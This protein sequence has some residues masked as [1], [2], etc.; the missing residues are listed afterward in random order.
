MVGYHGL[1]RFIWL[2]FF[3]RESEAQ[4]K[5]S[6]V[7]QLLRVTAQNGLQFPGFQRQ[8]TQ[9]LE[10]LRLVVPGAVCSEQDP[11][12]PKLTHHAHKLFFRH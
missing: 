9:A 11:L 1:T 8:G 12:S 5:Y 3:T 4:L 2:I 7:Q 10:G 6:K